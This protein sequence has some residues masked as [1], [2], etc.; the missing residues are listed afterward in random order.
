MWI[1]HLV[2]RFTTHNSWSVWGRWSL[3][4]CLAGHLESGSGS[5][6]GSRPCT[7][8]TALQ[9]Q[10][11]ASLMSSNLNVLQQYDLSLHH[12][13]SDILQSVFGWN[14]FPSAAVHGA[15][16]VPRVRRA[17]SHMADLGL[18]RPPNGPGRP[19]L[20]A[21]HQG[22]LVFRMPYMSSASGW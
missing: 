14:Y 1:P 8:H 3:P 17:S 6:P 22:P 15:A 19:G 4:A 16:P 9:L 21:F 2:C 5:Y 20:Q 13:A 12:K 11:D 10:L 18:W 7:L